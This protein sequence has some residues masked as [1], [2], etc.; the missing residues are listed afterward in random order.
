MDA[1][2]VVRPGDR[3]EELRY[4]VRSLLANLP[5]GQ[6]V[7]AGYTPSW[8]EPDV[9]LDVPQVPGAKQSNARANLEAAVASPAVSDPFL[10]LNDDMFVMAPVG[11]EMPMYHRGTVDEMIDE[12]RKLRTSGYMVALRQTRELLAM[13][14]FDPALCYEL[15]LPMVV[16]KTELA[17]ALELG[18]G[19]PGVHWRTVY[20]N[21]AGVGGERIDDCKVYGLREDFTGWPFLSSDDRRF[22]RYPVGK[23]VR[24][25][26]RTP[27]AYERDSLTY[28][29]VIRDTRAVGHSRP[30]VPRHRSRRVRDPRNRFVHRLSRTDGATTPR[31][32][33]HAAP[34]DPS[35]DP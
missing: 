4:S 9:R 23:F 30:A 17:R 33:H 16:R 29:N 15:H 21:I 27:S 26:F 11:D 24:A 22:A 34:V 12:Y 8:C 19:I 1:V 31:A 7:I 25:R 35:L 20:G 3:N 10:Y 2:Y 18:V 28:D 6:L 13:L 14:G 32:R 5:F